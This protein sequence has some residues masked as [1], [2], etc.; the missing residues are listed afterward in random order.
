MT[1]LNLNR[2]RV[3]GGALGASSPEPRPL[4]PTPPHQAGALR[5]NLRRRDRGLGLCGVVRRI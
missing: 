1:E 4:R 5:R 2:R 3:L